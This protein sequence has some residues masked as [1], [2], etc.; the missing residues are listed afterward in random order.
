MRVSELMHT[1]AVTCRSDATIAQ[2]ARLMRDRNVGSVVVVD[3]V[4]YLAGIVTDRDVAL[5]GVGEG[6]SG[7][8][9]VEHIMSRNL[10]TI[11]LHA[12]ASDAAAIMAKRSVRR[13]PVVDENDTPH[14]M[15]AL[16]DLVRQLGREADAVA[17]TVILQA[18]NL[19]SHP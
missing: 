9:A 4:G 3:D 17:D 11:P 8:L 10:A 14:G 5:R 6:R 13:L 18:A 19:S 16:D 12:D 15:L 1:P 7:D 2:V